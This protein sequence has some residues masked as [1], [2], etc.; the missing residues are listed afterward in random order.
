MYL[1]FVVLI[2]FISVITL[3]LSYLVIE[4]D[5]YLVNGLL[6]KYKYNKLVKEFKCNY[7]IINYTEAKAL[8]NI[9]F[10][11]YFIYNYKTK[12]IYIFQNYEEYKKFHN[13]IDSV[14]LAKKI[15]F[16]K[17]FFQI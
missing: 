5:K 10:K 15:Y 4:I 9:I 6:T 17:L 11:E 7:K 3:I 14:K 16:K 8:K 12:T 1:E 2:L 13:Y